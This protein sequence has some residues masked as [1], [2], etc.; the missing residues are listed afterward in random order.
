MFELSILID[1]DS[2]HQLEAQ[3]TGD[4]FPGQKLGRELISAARQKMRILAR[5][6]SITSHITHTHLAYLL[7]NAS[8]LIPNCLVHRSN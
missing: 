8:A 1:L 3:R 7:Y 6:I 5:A 2:Q 4:L